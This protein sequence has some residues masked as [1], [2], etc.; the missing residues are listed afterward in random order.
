MS[1]PNPVQPPPPIAPYHPPPAF[2][3]PQ[4]R[5]S[6]GIDNRAVIALALAITGLVLGV[7]LGLPGLICGPIAYFMGRSAAGRIEASGGTLGGR[8]LAL[9]GWIF[10]IVATAVGA[11]VSLIWLVIYLYSVSGPTP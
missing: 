1:V 4:Y 6:Q 8:N 2:P 9:F 7:V 5:S 11:V 3:P 10:G